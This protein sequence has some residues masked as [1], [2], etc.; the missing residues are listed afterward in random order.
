VVFNVSPSV[1][2][3]G[4]IDSKLQVRPNEY[5]LFEIPDQLVEQCMAS[6]ARAIVLAAW[7]A[8]SAR[9]EN[10]RFKEFI[11]WLRY[12]EPRNQR[13]ITLLKLEGRDYVCQSSK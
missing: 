7:L 8:A 4:D 12:G 2:L 3:L 11:A 10:N 5:A 6:V 1:V 9:R 13:I